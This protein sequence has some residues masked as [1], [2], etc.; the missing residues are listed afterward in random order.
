MFEL[1]GWR[2]GILPVGIKIEEWFICKVEEPKKNQIS[3]TTSVNLVKVMV[4]IFLTLAI[5]N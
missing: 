4:S 1:C 5:R 2:K 3:I